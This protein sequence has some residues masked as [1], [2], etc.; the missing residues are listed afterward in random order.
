MTTSRLLEINNGVTTSWIPFTTPGPSIVAGCSS[1]MYMVPGSNE[2]VAFDVWQGQNIPFA[3]QCLPTEVSRSYSQ[4]GTGSMRTSLGPFHCPS[5]FSTAT[6]SAIN[7]ISTSVM[8]CPSQYQLSQGSGTNM[9]CISTLTAGSVVPKSIYAPGGTWVSWN[10]TT[11]SN[12]GTT[13][14]GNMV[15]GYIFGSSTSS[16]STPSQTGTTTTTNNTPVIVQTGAATTTHATATHKPA[17]AYNHG[18]KTG[19]KAGIAVA[20]IVAALAI[21]ALLIFCSYRQRRQKRVPSNVY[22]KEG[23]QPSPGVVEKASVSDVRQT[24]GEEGVNHPMAAYQNA[25]PPTFAE[26]YETAGEHPRVDG[27]YN[28]QAGPHELDG[29]G[30]GRVS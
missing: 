18:L 17:K 21:I 12:V 25:L 11:I 20:A 29:H 10:D 14:V 24:A 8:C 6:T 16:S 5:D 15:N 28:N 7:G 23:S 2:I 26:G 4:A 13:I 27:M 19:A 22:E 9:N 1:A 30:Q 3:L